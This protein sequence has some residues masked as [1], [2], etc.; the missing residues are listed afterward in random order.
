MAAPGGDDTSSV[1]P[2]RLFEDDWDGEESESWED[3]DMWS[4]SVD[5]DESAGAPVTSGD[6]SGAPS[7]EDR[8]E[9][10]RY[11]V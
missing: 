9:T 7:A 2:P 1:M 5:D 11:T 3:E 4:G 6:R 8:R 10:Q